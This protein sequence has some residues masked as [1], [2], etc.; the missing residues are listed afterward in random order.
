[1][2]QDSCWKR[3]DAQAYSVRRTQYEGLS[4]ARHCR[5]LCLVALLALLAAGCE[6]GGHFTVFGYTTRP[7]YDTSIRTVRV[8]IFKNLSMRDSTREGVEFQLTQ[9]VVREI[10]LKTPYRVVGANCDADTE[11]EGTIVNFIKTVINRNQLNEVRE[12]QTT[13]TVEVVWRDLRTGEILSQ[14]KAKPDPIPVLSDQPPNVNRQPGGP[15][16]VTSDASFIPELG[17]S[18]TTSRQRNVDRLAVQ[19]VSM[20][21][22]PWEAPPRCNTPVAAPP[23]PP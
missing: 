22:A 3:R 6:D 4:T 19:I 5:A 15:V 8:P 18:I 11:L 23:P 7:N 20:M 13:L 21:E 16:T 10:G 9:A 17:E 1:M 12:A 2:V 14:P